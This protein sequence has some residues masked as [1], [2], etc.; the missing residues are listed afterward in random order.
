MASKTAPLSAPRILCLHGGG[1]NASVFRLQL[2]TIISRSSPSFR[3]V[4]VEAPFLCD[5]HPA[6]VDYFSDFA[7]F[8]RWTRWQPHHEEIPD[9][10]AARL[11]VGAC[12]EAMEA[13]GEG[14]GEWVGVLGFSQGAKIAASLLWAQERLGEQGQ[15]QTLLD[16]K[17][18]FGV[19][20]A[21]RNPIISLSPLLPSNQYIAGAGSMLSGAPPLPADA[22]GDHAVSIPTVHVHGMNDSGLELH[23]VMLE[24]Y[25]APGS[26]RLIEWD[27]DHRL[28]IK[29][30]DVDAVLDQIF[31]VAKEAGVKV[32]PRV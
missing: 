23:Q 21:G 1:T 17:F 8:R 26:T 6:I 14:T 12:R 27:G 28:P 2:R 22:K 5:A 16:A 4:F 18:R 9:D 25:F 10:E 29:P 31:A 3:Y 19:L 7:P 32:E 11:I 30:D 20:H 13:D 15:G 24:K